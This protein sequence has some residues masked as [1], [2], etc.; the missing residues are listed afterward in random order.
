MRYEFRVLLWL[1]A[2]FALIVWLM[3]KGH[4][5]TVAVAVHKNIVISL[6]DERCALT[7]VKMLPDRVTWRESG[8]VFE[9]CAGGHPSWLIV[10]Y[11]NDGT[12]VLL[13]PAAFK[14]VGVM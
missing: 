6:T 14:P 7:A 8:K 10:M 4:A 3:P 11:F 9:G 2:F 12:I 1:A 5:K 13:P